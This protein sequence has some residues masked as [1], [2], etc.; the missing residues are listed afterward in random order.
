MKCKC[1]NQ[2]EISYHFTSYLIDDDI[3]REGMKKFLTLE[4]KSNSKYNL[5]QLHCYLVCFARNN[6]FHCF[7]TIWLQNIIRM[8]ISYFRSWGTAV[9][10]NTFICCELTSL[11]LYSC[12]QTLYSR[13][14]KWHWWAWWDSYAAGHLPTDRLDCCVLLSL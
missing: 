9:N 1:N 13:H 8:Y 6:K 3:R 7:S 14:V 12:C 2:K 4:S 10:W 11:N 5:C